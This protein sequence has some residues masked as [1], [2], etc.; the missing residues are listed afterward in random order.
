ME[1]SS[2]PR[3]RVVVSYHAHAGVRRQ[4]SL[5][6]E[7][8]RYGADHSAAHSAYAIDSKSRDAESHRPGVDR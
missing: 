4:H 2:L 6:V 7:P 3:L 5:C 8:K 1:H